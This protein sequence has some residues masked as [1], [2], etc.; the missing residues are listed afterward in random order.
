MDSQPQQDVSEAS[1]S[2]GQT[3]RRTL[4]KA[5]LQ[6]ESNRKQG[7]PA[8]R[9]EDDVKLYLQPT[10]VHRYNNDFANYTTWVT[11]AQDGLKWDSVESD[12]VS[13][14]LK[15]SHDT[16]RHDNNDSQTNSNRTNNTHD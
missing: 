7:R 15:Q 9:W 1:K 10:E 13:S 16:D 8:K 5:Y 3:P 14:R 11:A 2:D 6:L 12:F 4:D